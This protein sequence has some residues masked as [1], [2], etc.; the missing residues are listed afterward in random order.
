M[1]QALVIFTDLDGSLLDHDGYSYSGALPALERVRALSIP[2]VFVTSKTR[3]EIE[4]LQ[5]EMGIREPFISENGGGIFF[6]AG[7]RG[8]FIPGAATRGGHSLIVLGKPYPELRRFVAER[9]GRFAIRGAGDLSLE[10]LVDLTGLTPGQAR[11]AKE[12][13]FTEPF[14]LDDDTKL[15]ALREEAL[16]A[17]LAITRGGRFHHLIGAGQ[18]KGRA[19]MR[20]KEIFLEN[21]AQGLATVGIGDRPNDVAMLAAVDV[22]VLIPHP[23]GQYEDL[24]LPHMLKAPHPGSLGWGEAVIGILEGLEARAGWMAHRR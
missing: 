2:L 24:A 17:G 20:V 12:R 5:E 13:E 1:T 9:K 4:R 6:P 21:M 7:Y 10:E 23:D 11:L 8:F 18:D 14:L 15:E 19:V 3:A 22:P 16:A